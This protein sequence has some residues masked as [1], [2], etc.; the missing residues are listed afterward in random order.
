M[1]HGVPGPIALT[2]LCSLLLGALPAG[3]HPLL[4]TLA[5]AVKSGQIPPTLQLDYRENLGEGRLTIALDGRGQA[6]RQT[7]KQKQVRRRVH[8][9]DL[10]RLLRLIVLEQ[11]W[12][13]KPNQPAHGQGTSVTL[14]LR[15]AG[16][17]VRFQAMLDL[18]KPRRDGLAV[19]RARILLLVPAGP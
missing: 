10:R 16:R 6:S 1:P 17:S 14:Q 7:G 19:I 12:L 9:E 15:L 13:P 2:L 5:R 4:V 3:G 11:P 18:E 8:P